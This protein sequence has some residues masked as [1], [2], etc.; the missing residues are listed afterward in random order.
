MKARVGLFADN[1]RC[2][3]FDIEKLPPPRRSCGEW[4]QVQNSPCIYCRLRVILKSHAPREKTTLAI[5]TDGT[6]F[7]LRAARKTA[8]YRKSPLNNR[9]LR[10]SVGT[11]ISQLLD[12]FWDLGYGNIFY[13]ARRRSYVWRL[14]KGA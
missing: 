6:H 10:P 2:G 7:P 4:S 12:I 14:R 5:R 9:Q 13:S 3:N 1:Q 11:I 8:T